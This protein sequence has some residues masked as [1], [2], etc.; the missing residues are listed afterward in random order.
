MKTFSNFILAVITLCFMN[1][2]SAQWVSYTTSV[3]ANL[4]ASY[5]LNNQTGW[6][7][8]NNGAIT[9]TTNGGINWT[10]ITGISTGTLYRVY[11]SDEN[12]GVIC[13]NQ[14]YRT[15]NGGIIWDTVANTGSVNFGMKFINSNTGWVC[16]VLGKIYKTTNAGMNWAAQTSGTTASFI[17][18]DFTDE[19][20]GYACGAGGNLRKTTDGGNNWFSLAPGIST[21][22]TELSFYNSLTGVI[23]G[24]SSV[25]LKTTDGG[26]SWTSIS[27]TTTRDLLG[28]YCMP[29]TS[30]VWSL[31][32][33]AGIYSTTTAANP[34]TRQINTTP[35][36]IS[37]SSDMLGHA[38]YSTGRILIS[39]TGGFDLQIPSVGH[40]TLSSSIIEVYWQAAS[41][42]DKYIIERSSNGINWSVCDSVNAGHEYYDDQNLLPGTKYYY[43][44]FARK[45]F[46]T[47][48]Y[49]AVTSGY[50]Y[51]TTPV[52]FLPSNGETVFTM[53][54]TLYWSKNPSATSY[55]MRVRINTSG[56]PY[57]TMAVTDTFVSIPQGVLQNGSE[58]LWSVRALNNDT[59]SQYT[60][61]RRFTPRETNYGSNQQSGDN[62]YYFANSTSGANLAPSKPN[63]N[64]RDTSG[65]INLIVNQT[66]SPSYGT[67]D[68]GWFTLTNIFGG[69]K[70]RFFGNDFTGLNIG[71][72]GYLSFVLGDLTSWPVEPTDAGLPSPG[73]AQI[74][75]PFWADLYY[76]APAFPS[77]LC[78][79]VTADELIITYSKAI[80]YDAGHVSNVNMCISFQVIIKHEPAPS[81]NSRIEIMYSYDETGSLFKS[82]YNADLLRPHLIGIE[83]LNS[84]NIQTVTYRFQNSAYSFT[85]KGPIFGSNL[86]LG[87][88]PENNT[89]PVEL[90]SF[91]SSVNGSNAKLEWI[92]QSELNNSGFEIQRTAAN[93]NNWKK[94]SFMQG[95]G[96][97]NQSQNYSYEDKNL[98]SGKYQYRLKQIDFNGNYEYFSLSNE[99]EIGVPKKFNLSQNYPNPFNPATKINFELPQYSKVKLSVF[100]VSGK[101]VSEIINGEKAAGY[102]TVEFNGANLA[103]GTYF[104]HI[105]AGDFSAVK[106]MV[107]VK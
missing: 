63:Y 102:Y 41:G 76:E 15:S 5:F 85:Y 54:P 30:Y 10:T 27:Y 55:E 23:A 25:L 88:G 95:N 49:S 97:T 44:V 62:L 94:I 105:Q 42:A 84:S 50:T 12:I 35:N 32:S 107:L 81:L 93:E 13:G 70:T 3:S 52:L 46:F 18:I 39:T 37:F 99:V 43:R 34:W 103:S 11:F 1:I 72:N 61:S 17:S 57:Y 67:L 66:G 101:L 89:L 51:L 73:T 33:G 56:S 83:G 6:A 104:Y 96:T 26:N 7:V 86:A 71:T 21:N 48:S 59:V 4:Q 2:A 69:N 91:T 14:I 28:V 68:D 60:N 100:D 31:L 8:G 20:T 36:K 98:S 92:T 24:N 38:P 74:I 9:K 65:S 22:L 19:N 45:S 75:A 90:A 79:K 80:M 82:N 78:Y 16:G 64:W 58:Y 87:F 47:G 106:K 29:N 77:R 53:T 40:N